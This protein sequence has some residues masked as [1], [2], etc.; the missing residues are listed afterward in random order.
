MISRT[1][2]HGTARRRGSASTASPTDTSARMPPFS[3]RIP[4]RR[5]D[6]LGRG[7][8]G[9][10]LPQAADRIGEEVAQ[11][12][13]DAGLGGRVHGDLQGV[14]KLAPAGEA[15][16][17]RHVGVEEL[18]QPDEPDN[19]P[20]R[21]RRGH[22]FGI[23]PVGGPPGRTPVRGLDPLTHLGGDPRPARPA[24]E[25]QPEVGRV[26]QRVLHRGVLEVEQPGPPAGQPA[27]L[28]RD[29][30]VGQ[31]GRPTVQDVQEIPRP[32]R[33]GCRRT[34]RSA[35]S[36]R[37]RRTAAAR[38]RPPARGSRRA[39]AR[40]PRPSPRTHWSRPPDRLRR[41]DPP[42]PGP[43]PRSSRTSS[44]ALS[45][46]ASRRG[47][48]S[49]PSSASR[50][51]AAISRWKPSR[52][53]GSP[54]GRR[55]LMITVLPSSAVQRSSRG[56]TAMVLHQPSVTARADSSVTVAPPGRSTRRP[57]AGGASRWYIN[58]AGI[59]RSAC[60]DLRKRE[61]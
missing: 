61:T 15:H 12:G 26:Q 35:P 34:R 51:S 54:G 22:A 50:S 30:A 38:S 56:L 47:P 24:V 40:R 3:P 45:S 31:C 55:I 16:R 42:E 4:V 11:A 60:F 29:I 59:S 6:R 46:V 32:P 21:D 49:Q 48:A 18:R 7:Q 9:P 8:T 36:A 53:R 20:G 1:W 23:C 17:V 10:A 52:R 58:A 2:R 25:R 44:P 28:R 57:Y 39:S 43:S 5:V 13:Q 27:V 37:G 33:R 41:A 19:G 14:E